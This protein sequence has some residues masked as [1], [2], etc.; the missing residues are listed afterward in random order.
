MEGFIGL[1]GLDAR[2][3]AP[4]RNGSDGRTPSEYE[5][6]MNIGDRGFPGMP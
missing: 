5:R 1:P 4:G 2:D 6:Q 3:G